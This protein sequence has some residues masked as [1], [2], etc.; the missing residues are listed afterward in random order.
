MNIDIESIGL[1]SLILQDSPKDRQFILCI[2][3]RSNSVPT[4]INF[5]PNTENPTFYGYSNGRIPFYLMRKGVI[6][7]VP[8]EGY[9][10]KIIS[11]NY[12]S[13]AE[14]IINEAK[15]WDIDH[16]LKVILKF[17][18]LDN[19]TAYSE[20]EV[21]LMFRDKA[22]EYIRDYAKDRDTE[23]PRIEQQSI[24]KRMTPKQTVKEILKQYK[25]PKKQKALIKALSDILPKNTKT[26]K[27]EIHTG[28]LS[29]LRRDTLTTIKKHGLSDILSIESYKNGFEYFYRLIINKS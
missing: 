29:S 9:M 22:L 12:L 14:T 11:S 24:I 27:G 6:R 21:F 17:I 5:N 8:H 10:K 26:L 1:L 3:A 15:N 25:F 16:K 19:K 23:E 2:L 7:N 18:L 4:R 13:Y 28:D 20:A